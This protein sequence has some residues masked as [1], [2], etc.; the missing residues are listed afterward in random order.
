MFAARVSSVALLAIALWTSQAGNAQTI[1]RVSG[2]G[3]LVRTTGQSR[4]TEPLV[5]IVRNAAGQP[6]PNWPVAWTLTGSGLLTNCD[7]TTSPAVSDTTG[8]VIDPGGK[9]T[10]YYQGF[11]SL[12]SFGYAAATITASAMTTLGGVATSSVDFYATTIAV[13]SVS[14]VVAGQPH[15]DYPGADRSVVFSGR[16]GVQDT[17]PIKMYMTAN[18]LLIKNVALKLYVQSDG[19]TGATIS[20]AGPEGTAL[21]NDL[22][23]AE[24]Y[25]IYGGKAGS[26]TFT[27]AMG[28]LG[29]QD[30][31]DWNFS[32]TPG[33]PTTI[34][35]LSGNGQSGTA[36]TTLNGT[37]LAQ[38]EDG[39]GN[40]LPNVP[41]AWQPIPA[42]SANFSNS[43][44]ASDSQGRV[45]SRVTLGSIPG[46]GKV[47]LY[48]TNTTPAVEALFDFTVNLV[49]TDFQKIS[50]D[51]QDAP[52]G[53]DFEQ[54]LTVQLNA[55]T[56]PV[57]GATVQF[58]V[59]RGDATVLTPNATTN[60]QGQAQTRVRAGSASGEVEIAASVG[61]RTLTFKLTQR[62]PGPSLTPSSFYAHPFFAAGN[63]NRGGVAPGSVVT[64]AAAGIA[65]GITGY[66]APYDNWGPLPMALGGVT[67]QF[68][69]S[70]APIYHV[71][72]VGTTE[73]VTVQVPFDVVPGQVPVTVNVQNGGSKTATIPVVASAPALFET[74]MSDG[75][76]RAV[77]VKPNGTFVSL[78]NPAR[79]G[80]IVKVYATGLGQGSPLIST[81]QY[82]QS[83]DVPLPVAGV[84]GE[85]V[86]VVSA[87]YA[88]NLIGV[89]EIEVEIPASA[90]P[91]L[92][93]TI[94]LITYNGDQR[95]D[96]NPSLLPIQ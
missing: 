32:V 93:T 92:N 23:W 75:R 13:D 82:G 55:Q 3:Q 10:C 91:N 62:L 96:S 39:A 94:N 42:G 45:S 57:S 88:R 80:E 37:L 83:E 79:P 14:G 43:S 77:A 12:G 66:V 68:G 47:R 36:G 2:N 31:P 24:C 1:T 53:T 58:A 40:T 95:M 49:I 76:A 64:I 67:V 19:G 85:G 69:S 61:G 78:Q 9:A 25:P 29:Y 63:Q 74:V 89:Y 60:A 41:V 18:G 33:P 8:K 46:A 35:I 81:N 48:T 52:I 30:S 7:A 86:R 6:L 11:S 70:W 73:F 26:G 17:T 50:G 72:K 56:G 4:T 84:A 34:R 87:R 90:S 20:C 38:V 5:A 44:T 28:G 16:A 65:P 59:T 15:L 22:G 21:T 27:I 71:A 54:P 51:N